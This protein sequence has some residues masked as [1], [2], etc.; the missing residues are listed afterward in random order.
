VIL[1][2]FSRSGGSLRA[3]APNATVNNPAWF[4]DGDFTFER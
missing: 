2:E 1:S 4:I 3:D